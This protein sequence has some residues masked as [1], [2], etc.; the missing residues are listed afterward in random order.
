[1]TG[2]KE[3]PI[4]F[5]APMVRAILEGRKSV[6]RRAVKGLGLKWLDDFT[7]EYVADAANSLCPCG[8]PGD[9][10]WVREAW[11]ADAQLNA[12]PPPRA[13]SRRTNLLSRRWRHAHIGLLDDFSGSRGP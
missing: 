7:P 5:S 12:V 11:A 2:I 1:M 13:K 10:L 4:L 6:T 3:R 8:Q 9:R